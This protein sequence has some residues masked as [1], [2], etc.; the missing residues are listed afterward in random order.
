[1]AAATRSSSS[2]FRRQMPV[3]PFGFV[4]G[5]LGSGLFGV[6]ADGRFSCSELAG[7]RHLGGVVDEGSSFGSGLIPSSRAMSSI[8]TPASH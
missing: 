7:E 3:V 6:G 1:M 2:R 5:R 8:V 4:Q